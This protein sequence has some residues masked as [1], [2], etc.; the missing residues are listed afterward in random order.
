MSLGNMIMQGETHG[1]T[2]DVYTDIENVYLGKLFP[3]QSDAIARTRIEVPCCKFAVIPAAILLHLGDFSVNLTS[4]V[5][6]FLSVYM[7]M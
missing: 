6:A 2:P 1:R 7:V 5:P 3:F 4:E